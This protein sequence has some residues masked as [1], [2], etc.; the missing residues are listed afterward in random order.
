M[1]LG[2]IEAMNDCASED[3]VQ[4]FGN[5]SNKSKLDSRGSYEE[6]DFG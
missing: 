4:I 6:I 1:Y 5:D 3:T 2:G